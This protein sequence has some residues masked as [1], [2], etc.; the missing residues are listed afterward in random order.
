[1]SAFIAQDGK[2]EKRAVV[3]RFFGIRGC[4]SLV[5]MKSGFIS[6]LS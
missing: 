5:M 2:D 4:Y 6:K 1:M 3:A